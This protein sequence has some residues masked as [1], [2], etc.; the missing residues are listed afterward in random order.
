M[1]HVLQCSTDNLAVLSGT[2]AND[3]TRHPLRSG[4]VVV[5][6]DLTT[7]VGGDTAS[8]PVAWHDPSDSAVASFVVGD[9]VLVVGT[10][11]R[12]FFRVGGQTQSRTE[13]I[14]DALVPTR[15][16][17]STRS[18]LAAVAAAVT[19]VDG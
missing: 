18:L 1:G 15:R 7:R 19:P 10:V 9:A 5:S 12:R 13:V 11:R 3:P 6:F 17:K 14:V 2:V 8:V 16:V 4:S